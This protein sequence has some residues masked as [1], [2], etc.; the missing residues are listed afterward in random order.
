MYV[1]GVVS[2]SCHISTDV[3]QGS[4][5]GPLLFNI[6]INDLPKT[7]T[8]FSTRLYADDTSLTASGSDLDSLLCEINSHLQAIYEWLCS[9]KLTLN[10]TKAKYI[11]FM[12][13]QKES[14][15]LYPP[16][17]VANVYL[18][19][20]FC[21]KFLG[22]YIDC[23]LTWHDNIDYI[24]GKISKN[25]NIMVKLKRH[26]SKQHLLVCITLLHI[27]TLLMLVC[28][29]AVSQTL[30]GSCKLQMG[31]C[32]RTLWGNNYN[33]PLSQIVKLQ[34]KAVRVINDVPLMEPITPH[35]L[36]LHL[37][38][39]PDIVK[40]NTCMLF[41]DYFNH[42]KFPNIP[43]SLVS[44][45]HNYNTHSASSNQIF[46]PS[47]RTNF[48]RFRPSIIGCFFWNNIPHFIR[49]KPSKNI[50]RKALLHWYLAQYL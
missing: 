45:L 38:K 41:Y 14:Y 33:A 10:L 4:I 35:Y 29:N 42:E 16:L 36:S 46:I 3:P 37:L 13:R 18:E 8:F 21:V 30:Y 44:E 48:R 12:P 22:V 50:F 40:L 11:I 7:S 43:V 49:D 31:S 9:N 2:D 23:H 5:I 34:N 24:Y 47:F 6:F 20:S 27:F 39:F 32:A 19:K 1:N 17:T 26:V 15:N 25:V 28:E